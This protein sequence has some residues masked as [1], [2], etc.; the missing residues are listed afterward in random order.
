[1]AGTV[2]VPRGAAR[3]VAL[4]A[5]AL[6]LFSV[7]ACGGKDKGNGGQANGGNGGT[8]GDV[9]IG[10]SP[11]GTPSPGGGGAT[12]PPPTGQPAPTY[13]KDAR[14][15]SV[16]F[17]TAWGKKDYTRLGQLGALSA[18]QQ[19]KDSVNTGGVPNTNWHYIKCEGA[20]GSNYCTF[21]NDNGDETVIRLT[22]ELVG[23][24]QAVI[25]APLDRTR[26]ANKPADYVGLF[27][28]AWAAGNAQRML[29]YSTQDVVNWAKAN[30]PIT[31]LSPSQCDGVAGATYVTLIGAG[32]DLGRSATFKVSNDLVSQGRKHAITDH[33]AVVAVGACA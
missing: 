1:M 27:Q 22:N 30:Q 2:V 3:A 7:V 8:G 16:A 6:V 23:K 26:Y 24:P 20:M 9:T 14:A 13:P 10:G 11:S 29:A 28:G 21:R 17:L 12:T 5:A 4:V 18:V 32:A 19:V 25:E 15:Y 31:S 33:T